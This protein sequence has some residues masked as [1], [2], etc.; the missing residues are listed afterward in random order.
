MSRRT[1]DVGVLSC[2]CSHDEMA[3]VDEMKLRAAVVSDADL[4]RV[5]LWNLADHLQLDPV[6]GVFDLRP[7]L[8]SST[9]RTAKAAR[10]AAEQ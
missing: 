3:C 6:N 9:R 2:A 10:K 7:N 1:T 8:G 5:A 4:V